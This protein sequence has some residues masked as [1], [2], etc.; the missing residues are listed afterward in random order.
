G[1]HPVIEETT[2]SDNLDRLV[3]LFD[4]AALSRGDLQRSRGLAWQEKLISPKAG[5]MTP[6][7]FFQISSHAQ[8]N[9]TNPPPEYVDGAG[10]VGLALIH[11]ARGAMA[12]LEA[13]S[14]EAQAAARRALRFRN[15]TTDQQIGA[16]LIVGLACREHLRFSD[17]AAQFA[18]LTRLRRDAD[19]WY[20]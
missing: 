14:L 1:I 17:A 5:H 6:S 11:F 19:D 8:Q 18:E 20:Y 15:L 13:V 4:E 3:P 16:L 9:V 2:P 7:D 12:E 10:E